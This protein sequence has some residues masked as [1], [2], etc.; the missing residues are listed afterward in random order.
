[1]MFPKKCWKKA[2]HS[3]GN[4]LD[5]VAAGDIKTGVRNSRRYC[6][7]SAIARLLHCGTCIAARDQGLDSV[8]LL[9]RFRSAEFNDLRLLCNWPW[10][11]GA[12]LNVAGTKNSIIFFIYPLDSRKSTLRASISDRLGA[13][14]WSRVIW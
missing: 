8:T 11:G 9:R 2:E 4:L 1:M 10:E 6:C 3:A 12:F 7:L 14:E 13:L 5:E